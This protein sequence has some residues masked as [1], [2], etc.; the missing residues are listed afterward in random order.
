[1]RVV[2][3]GRVGGNHH[4]VIWTRGARDIGEI[5]VAQAEGAR[6]RPVLGDVG[7]EELHA[8]R[9]LRTRQASGVAMIRVF[10]R[11]VR[12]VGHRHSIGA[13]ELPEVVVEP[14][15]L[16]EHDDD[17]LDWRGYRH[18]DAGA[19]L[20]RPFHLNCPG[21]HLLGLPGTDVADFTIDVVIPT[22]AGHRV[23]DGFAKLV[24]AGRRDRVA[25][26]Q[27]ADAAGAIRVR[28]DRVINGA[29]DAVVIAPK[30]GARELAAQADYD[31]R[32][33]VH[34]VEGVRGR[35]R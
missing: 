18:S 5:R 27:R 33:Q 13:G 15:V 7:L 6:P 34:E 4:E 32:R 17:V 31:A 14:V 22:L 1:M 19:L 9:G 11:R 29:G 12:A 28:H 16:F 8:R 21:T 3:D 26:I 30:P 2:D 23:G 25:N 20:V 10:R 35:R 24:R